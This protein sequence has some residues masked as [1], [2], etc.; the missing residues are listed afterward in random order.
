MLQI[1]HLTITHKKDLRTILAD[2]SLTLND[3]DR[4]A[5]IGEE[6][7]GK[8]TL[9]KLIHDPESV[10]GYVQWEGRIT[11][12]RARLGYL[13]QQLTPEEMYL[14]AAEFWDGGAPAD[15]GRAAKLLN[16][17]GLGREIAGDYRP[18]STLSGGERVKLRLAKLLASEPDI[19][20]LD[21]PTNDLDLQTLYWLE[22][23]LLGCPVPVLYVSHDEA[24]L[25]KTA[26]MIVHLEALRRKTLPRCTVA[27][28]GFRDYMEAR[29]QRFHH[30]AQISRWEHRD[31]RQKME[32]FLRIRN[33]V[34]HQQATISRQDPHGGQLLKKK[35]HAVK[36]MERR[37]AQEKERLTQMPEMEEA[38]FLRFPEEGKVPRGKTVLDFALPVLEVSQRVLSR[39]IR[40]KVVGPERIGIIGDNGCGKTSLLRAIAQGFTHRQDIRVAYMPQNYADLL[41]PDLNPVD[42]LNPTGDPGRATKIRDYLGSLRFTTRE[43]SHPIGELS[44]GQQAKIFFLGMIL[45]EAQV[46]LLDEPTRNFSPLSSP[47]I[48]HILA[49]FGGAIISVSHDR[50]YLEEVCQ[51]IYALTPEG[52][53]QVV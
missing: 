15:P 7:N 53:V 35:M 5:I 9:L 32:R 17:L 25:E 50:R 41:R 4:A 24:L 39:G 2:L 51:K 37:F 27:R 49:E 20:L 52:L 10:S 42:H 48:R 47:V 18:M 30:Q 33:K 43:M 11:T 8:S 21:E 44:G 12:G 13:A 29:A 38:I 28:V 31:F 45:N 6:G 19:L 14:T 3:G 34:E 36:S 1:E 22:D 26:N 40:L 23:F 46:L 16:A